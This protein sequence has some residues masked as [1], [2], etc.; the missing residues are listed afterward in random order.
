MASHKFLALLSIAL[1]AGACT[2]GGSSKL[3]AS[4]VEIGGGR[5]MYMECDGVGSPTVVLVSGKG[6]RADTWSTNPVDPQKPEATVFRQVARLTRVC[7]YDRP[8]TV[9]VNGEPSR[10]SPVPPPAKAKDGVAELHALLTAVHVPEP[11]VIVGHSYGGLIA[12]LY[13]STYPDAVAGLVLEDALSEGL[14]DGLTAPQREVLETINLEPERVDTLSSFAQVISAPRVRTVPMVILTA[15]LQPIS[16]QD[17]ASG[18]FP[19]SVT[20]EF[21]DALWSAQIA[22]QDRLAKLFPGARHITNTNSRHYIHLE[23]PQV[24]V[25]AIHEVVDAVRGARR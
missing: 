21:V 11:Y 20:V 10:S 5:T 14:Y 9:G 6:N 2:E 4:L 15:D 17:V 8:A 23:Q 3:S 24:V 16:A 19:P 12:R 18:A 25:D 1:V 13:A 22:A 7:A